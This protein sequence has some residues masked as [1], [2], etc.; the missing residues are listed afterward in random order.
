MEKDM[1]QE[2]G[3]VYV[4]EIMIIENRIPYQLKQEQLYTNR[5]EILNK[6]EVYESRIK[7]STGGR[8]YVEEHQYYLE[9]LDKK[10]KEFQTEIEKVNKEIDSNYRT[11]YCIK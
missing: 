1:I 7:E 2:D 11:Y 5:R 9:Y 8:F 10:I 6:I 4:D 3:E